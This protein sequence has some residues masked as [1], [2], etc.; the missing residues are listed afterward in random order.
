[1]NTL[2]DALAIMKMHAEA[3][4]F[5]PGYWVRHLQ[6]R[7]EQGFFKG[8]FFGCAMQNDID[9]E[10]ED[11]IRAF[12]KKYGMPLWLG[13]LSEHMFESVSLKEAKVLPVELLTALVKLP[14]DYD[15]SKA[16][17]KLI[18][19]CLQELD[20][21]SPQEIEILGELISALEEYLGE[22][23]N[24]DR[25]HPE[26]KSAMIDYTGG[27]PIS[28]MLESLFLGIEGDRRGDVFPFKD[29]E[30]YIS[31][32]CDIGEETYW[33]KIK[34]NLLEILV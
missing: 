17:K 12:C 11:P 21:A 18:L 9:V 29:L 14:Q 19:S 32:Y 10:E 23:F 31:R 5:Y 24:T 15:Y 33:G 6:G 20:P 4:R 25:I 22:D 34:K 1:M 7:D 16:Y 30:S 13:Y 3:D 8:C 27:G 28:S 26:T 2:N